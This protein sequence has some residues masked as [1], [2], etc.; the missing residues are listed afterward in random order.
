MVR[1]SRRRIGFWWCQVPPL[2]GAVCHE[3]EEE[4]EVLEV[5]EMSWVFEFGGFVL[6]WK[7]ENS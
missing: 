4:E 6:S 1:R 5:E 2:R 7:R 3:C